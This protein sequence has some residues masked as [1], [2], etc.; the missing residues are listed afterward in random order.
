MKR[1]KRLLYCTVIS[2]AAV[3]LAAQCAPDEKPALEPTVV[4]TKYEDLVVTQFSYNALDKYGGVTEVHLRYSYTELALYSDGSTSET[5]LKDS[6]LVVYECAAEIDLDP[7]T[8]AVTL[9]ANDSD[10]EK[11][12]TVTVTVSTPD[13]QMSKSLTAE[14]LQGSRTCEATYSGLAVNAFRYPDAM[15]ASGAKTAPVLEYSYI[16]ETQWSDGSVARDTLTTGASLIFGCTGGGAADDDGYVSADINDTTEE[17]TY[18]V[19]LIVCVENMSVS[20]S[21]SVTQRASEDRIVSVETMQMPIVLEPHTVVRPIPSSGLRGINVCN[22]DMMEAED[23]PDI[24]GSFNLSNCLVQ[25][26]DPAT[27]RRTYAEVKHTT[28]RTDGLS[29]ETNRYVWIHY[30]KYGMKPWSRDTICLEFVGD[31]D[32]SD[33]MLMLTNE[34]VSAAGVDIRYGGGQLATVTTYLSGHR[35]TVIIKE[36]VWTTETSFP[37]VDMYVCDCSDCVS[38]KGIYTHGG[39]HLFHRDAPLDD[40]HSFNNHSLVSFDKHGYRPHCSAADG[41]WSIAQLGP[42]EM[43]RSRHTLTATVDGCSTSVTVNQNPNIVAATYD[44]RSIRIRDLQPLGI[45]LLDAPDYCDYTPDSRPKWATMFDSFGNTVYRGFNTTRGIHYFHETDHIITATSA[46]HRRMD[47]K[48]V[49]YDLYENTR[50]FLSGVS[51]HELYRSDRIGYKGSTTYQFSGYTDGALNQISEAD[52]LDYSWTVTA[53]V[54]KDDGHRYRITHRS[55]PDKRIK[56]QSQQDFFI[57]QHDDVPDDFAWTATVVVSPKASVNY[58]CYFK[59]TSCSYI[60]DWSATDPSLF[61]RECTWSFMDYHES[62]WEFVHRQKIGGILCREGGIGY[63]AVN[64]EQA[65]ESVDTEIVRID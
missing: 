42:V 1:T 36:P 34:T 3:L 48:P 7:V 32:S 31:G 17:R 25:A 58:A 57:P 56:T 41:V 40:A 37:Y 16:R 46:R 21:A 11:R 64:N 60:L 55:N 6:A 47:Q 2:L 27:G 54:V 52:I 12:I 30:E 18:E 33:D 9:P 4:Q 5:T 23:L 10:E 15:P 65:K 35:D 61:T 62:L 26:T 13:G 53:E 49:W 19:S 28:E 50:T 24:S 20:A 29:D 45:N 39:A 43:H 38:Y 44:D 14:V 22:N 8:G 51:R 59:E 63:R